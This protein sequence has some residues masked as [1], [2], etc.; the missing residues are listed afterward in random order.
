[1]HLRGQYLFKIR[2]LHEKYGPVIR[3]NPY[4]LHFSTPDFFNDIYSQTE[5]RDV[6]LWRKAGFGID[7]SMLTTVH[8]DLHRKRRSALAPMF[9]K[10]RINKL[11]PVLQERVDALMARVKGFG[12]K[13]EV[14]NLKHGFA[15]FTAGKSSGRKCLFDFTLNAHKILTD[16]AMEYF[17]G[18][19]EHK[20]EAE[21]FDVDF[22]NAIESGFHNTALME[23][24]P[25]IMWIMT[26]VAR[27]TPYWILKKFL[28]KSKKTTFIAV[29]RQIGNM[30]RESLAKNTLEKEESMKH[31]MFDQLLASKLPPEEKTFRRLVQEGGLMVSAATV[32]TAWSLTVTSY[33]LV[34]H[35]DALKKVKDELAAAFPG[36]PDTINDLGV[37]GSLPFLNACIQES[38]RIGIGPSH[39]SPRISPDKAVPFTD[40]ETGNTWMVPA[41]TPMSMS[42]PLLFRDASIFPDPY[43]FKPERW[44]ETPGLEKYQFAFSKGTRNC[45]GITLAYT[46]MNMM[47]AA[48]FSRYGSVG[49]SAPGDVGKLELYETDMSDIECVGDGGVSL[50]KEGSVGVRFRVIPTVTEKV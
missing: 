47:I 5:K 27:Q 4:E 49:Y 38:L 50:V 46:E 48:L 30:V 11:Q 18:M 19:S 31:T 14:I 25:W 33:N 40:P 37:L 7:V 12:A 8:H 6:W 42:H 2:D 3:I 10:Q 36:G 26:N 34:S 17:F 41:G 29:Q 39:R 21:D 44:I 45:M 24:F 22:H 20:I 9:S 43:S 23:H 13:G 32:S 28:A 15:A 1:M 16:V 35:P